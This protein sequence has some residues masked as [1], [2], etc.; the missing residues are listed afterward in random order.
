MLFKKPAYLST[1]YKNILLSYTR[2]G[3]KFSLSSC[4]STISRQL[5]NL[6]HCCNENAFLV[7]KIY[8]EKSSKNVLSKVS[9][10]EPTKAYSFHQFSPAFRKHTL[11][12][13]GCWK[14]IFF[15]LNVS[16]KLV[17]EML[18]TMFYLRCQTKSQQRHMDSSVLIS[19][20]K[21]YITLTRHP[22]KNMLGRESFFLM[23]L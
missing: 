1:T 22:F 20:W 7:I 17:R 3:N 18:Q 6:G 2:L 15:L 19:P 4:A 21:L 12:W 23:S 5:K 16:V 14:R 11:I 8:K 10:K 9:N 13:E